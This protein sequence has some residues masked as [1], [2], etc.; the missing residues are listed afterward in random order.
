MEILSDVV[1]EAGD[2]L[3]LEA[4]LDFKPYYEQ[5]HHFALIS[6]KRSG[7]LTPRRVSFSMFFVCALVVGMIALSAAEVL[8]LLPG[9][10]IVSTIYILTRILT[11]EQVSF[12][13]AVYPDLEDKLGERLGLS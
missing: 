9:G 3:V 4:T 11:W 8:T 1:L 12:I 13:N 6:E 10:F 7:S 2:V 5:S